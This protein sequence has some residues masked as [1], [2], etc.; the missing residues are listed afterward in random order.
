MSVRQKIVYPTL[1]AEIARRGIKK[2]EIA[3]FLGISPRT[4]SNKLSASIGFSL[5]QGLTIWKTFFSDVPI[6]EL[7]RKE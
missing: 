5:E 1:E 4:F 7:F 3:K 6:D 2:Y